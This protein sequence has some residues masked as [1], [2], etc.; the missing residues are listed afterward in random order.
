MLRQA[1]AFEG[2]LSLNLV[3]SESSAEEEEEKEERE[4]PETQLSKRRNKKLAKR[5]AKK[6]KKQA[7][8]K[9][10]STVTKKPV[11]TEIKTKEKIVI[12]DDEGNA[13]G[14]Y[15]D[16]EEEEDVVE[17]VV[18][19]EAKTKKTAKT[20][21]APK[22]Q[23]TVTKT[24]ES[25]KS[26][27]TTEEKEE[28]EEDNEK[29]EQQKEDEEEKE[30][31]SK[32][33]QKAN[34]EKVQQLREKIASKLQEFKEKRRAPGTVA[35][36]NVRTRAEIL[37]ARREKE[38]ISKEKAQLK[39]KR[40]AEDVGEREDDNEFDGDSDND[41]IDTSG[42]MFSSVQFA[43]GTKA[44]AN[45]KEMRHQKSKKGPRDILGQLK[46]VEARKAKIA[47]MDDEKR[48]DI[49][50]KNK[51]GKAIAQAEGA[52]VRDDV[53]KLKASLK[54]HTNKKLKSEKTWNE[55]KEKASIDQSNKIQKR[56]ENIALKIERSKLFGKKAK[57][58][59]GFE[60]GIAKAR[61]R[62]IKEATDTK[63]KGKGK[64]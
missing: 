42:L 5:Q 29:E 20:V 10:N 2:L 12:Y 21:E 14:E 64:K 63:K 38:K 41:G 51:W 54:R 50:E 45:L 46:H 62:R 19:K 24:K 22:K 34:P 49:E 39:R 53:K 52:K 9:A 59:A 44:T 32:S 13:V 8:A 25:V 48:A 15:S 27:P 18:E 28:E 35:N 55:R 36:G 1:D 23:K 31:P 16:S 4:E 56:N 17:K 11:K 6:Q 57:K 47:A 60:G 33:D 40:E 37:A 7:E 61:A 30:K 43:D 3:E 58:R 26:K